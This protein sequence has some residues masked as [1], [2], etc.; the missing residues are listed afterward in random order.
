METLLSILPETR[1]ILSQL[2]AARDF[3]CGFPLGKPDPVPPANLA[4]GLRLLN[5][6]KERNPAY[7]AL[8]SHTVPQLPP[9]PGD[10]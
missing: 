4:Q 2:A 9:W 1:A 10:Y 8:V 7:K 5:V 3:D 6:W